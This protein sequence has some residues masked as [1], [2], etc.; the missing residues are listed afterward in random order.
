MAFIHIEKSCWICSFINCI[1]GSYLHN[2]GNKYFSTE[3]IEYRYLVPK[4]NKFYMF[5]CSSYLPFSNMDKVV[6]MGKRCILYCVF[7]ICIYWICMV[8]RLVV[9]INDR[10][11]CIDSSLVSL[12]LVNCFPYNIS[13][14]FVRF[15]NRIVENTVF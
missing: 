6:D 8:L 10:R 9:R 14:F 7:V 4:F 11:N 12:I 3:W 5:I 13:S 1:Y 15:G 2:L